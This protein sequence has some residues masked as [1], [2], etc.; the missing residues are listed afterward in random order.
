MLRVHCARARSAGRGQDA[1]VLCNANDHE[2]YSNTLTYQLPVT[3]EAANQHAFV[4]K[5]VPNPPLDDIREETVFDGPATDFGGGCRRSASP[6]TARRS[7]STSTR[8][9]RS[10]I[11][12]RIP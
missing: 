10:C 6:R 1:P 4:R 11:R 3:T 5:L 9:R 2:I 7:A 8:D 12:S